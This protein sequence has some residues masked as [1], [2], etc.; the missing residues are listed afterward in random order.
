MSQTLVLLKE[1][2]RALKPFSAAKAGDITRVV[3]LVG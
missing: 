3:I 1:G 2:Y